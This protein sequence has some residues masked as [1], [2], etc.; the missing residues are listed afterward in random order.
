VKD[1]SISLSIPFSYEIVHHPIYRSVRSVL[2]KIHRE[3]PGARFTFDLSGGSKDFCLALMSFAPWLGG[4][5]YSAFDEKSL[6]CIPLPDRTVRSM[7]E[8][9]NYQT[10]L[11]VLLRNS[12]APAVSPN[13]PYVPRQY[14][15][16]QVWPYYV[17]SRA[18]TPNPD[19]P[20]VHYK[21][22]QKPANNL[23]QQTFSTFMT[24]LRRAGFIKE[25]ENRENR[26]ERAYRLTGPGETAFRFFGVPATNSIV[27]MM[28]ERS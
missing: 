4:D 10:I 11:A 8:N 5:V 17:R 14:L 16:Q 22:G 23:S 3:N 26:K 7:M 9:V 24:Q 19:D 27:K 15:F 21:R 13:Y 2:T 20:V 25:E 28:L 18:R 6:R 12:P 1:L